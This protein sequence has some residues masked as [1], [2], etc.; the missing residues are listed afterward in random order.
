MYIVQCIDYTGYSTRTLCAV[1]EEC[2]RKELIDHS[3]ESKFYGACYRL[4]KN[5]LR[6]FSCTLRAH[7]FVK[8]DFCYDVVYQ[9]LQKLQH[10]I[11]K[12]FF[13]LW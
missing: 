8:W 10:N 11:F 13:N 3:F 4:C 2:S 5:V 6:G 1:C 9:S 12:P 7:K